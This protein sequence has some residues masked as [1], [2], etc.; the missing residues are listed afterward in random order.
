MEEDE[1]DVR[2]LLSDIDYIR[3][4]IARAEA[5]LRNNHHNWVRVS[6]IEQLVE[7]AKGYAAAMI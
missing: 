1:I 7:K 5:D 6:A 2:A 4:V 3:T